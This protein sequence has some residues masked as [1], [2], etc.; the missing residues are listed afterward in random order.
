MC[1]S[2]LP[3]TRSI[4]SLNLKNDLPSTTTEDSRSRFGQQLKSRITDNSE[5]KKGEIF[6]TRISSFTNLAKLKETLEEINSF[7]GA[8]RT[9]NIIYFPFLHFKE[10]SVNNLNL[11]PSLK[12]RG[13]EYDKKDA[14]TH[15]HP[16]LVLFSYGK[17]EKGDYNVGVWGLFDGDNENISAIYFPNILND[18][19][20]SLYGE[21]LKIDFES[22]SPLYISFPDIKDDSITYTTF[23]NELEGF[24]SSNI[25]V[26]MEMLHRH[27]SDKNNSNISELDINNT[28]C[29]V[30]NKISQID[31]GVKREVNPLFKNI[32]ERVLGNENIN[33]IECIKCTK[34][35][36]KNE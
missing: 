18:S 32:W 15:E 3:A 9:L 4:L 28:L 8:P 21:K 7:N 27:T 2:D 1:S 12:F 11:A 30:C 13:A 19:P 25:R 33:N 31:I 22:S 10:A 17:A 5:N 35:K 34:V 36:F 26:L 6:F 14:R 24:Y 23:K 29:K 20:L 16:S